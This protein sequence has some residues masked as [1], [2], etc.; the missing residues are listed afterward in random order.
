MTDMITVTLTFDTATA[1]D[2]ELRFAHRAACATHRTIHEQM[3]TDDGRARVSPLGVRWATLE[4]QAVTVRGA[5]NVIYDEMA[6]RREKAT[7]D[8]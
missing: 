2:D 8:A 1:T 7:A 6:K 3:I 5:V 4:A